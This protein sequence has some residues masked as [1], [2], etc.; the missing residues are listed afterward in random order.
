MKSNVQTVQTNKNIQQE[1]QPEYPE[2]QQNEFD[3]FNSL[4]RSSANREVS[5]ENKEESQT[6]SKTVYHEIPVEKT[7]PQV[8]Q[9]QELSSKRHVPVQRKK[10]KGK[11]QKE[12]PNYFRPSESDGNGDDFV[13]NNLF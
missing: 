7:K 6:P 4:G 3:F 5:K 12:E 13:P 8:D 10:V 1:V 11:V 2:E 9:V